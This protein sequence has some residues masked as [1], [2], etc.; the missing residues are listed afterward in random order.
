MIASS[1]YIY[2]SGSSRF[3]ADGADPTHGLDACHVG[4]EK[5]AVYPVQLA[6]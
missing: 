2:G 5:L 1:I 6:S 3:P 4:L